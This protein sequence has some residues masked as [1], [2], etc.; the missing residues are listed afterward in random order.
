MFCRVLSRSPLL[1]PFDAGDARAGA[2]TL[3][4]PGGGVQIAEPESAAQPDG[5]SSPAGE[6]GPESGA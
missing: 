2:G 5:D 1:K 3:G 4:S 6:P